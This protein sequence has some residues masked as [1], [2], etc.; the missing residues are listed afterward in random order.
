MG[1][2]VSAQAHR[3]VAGRG[4]DDVG[5]C[6]DGA[7]LRQADVG[8]VGE[9]VDAANGGVCAALEECGEVHAKSDREIV[10]SNY[11]PG[12]FGP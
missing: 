5:A 9:G 2:R 7:V 3:H 6:D 4:I 11:D 1:E 10:L 12:G 8:P